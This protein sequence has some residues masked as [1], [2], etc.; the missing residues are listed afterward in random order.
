[1]CFISGSL[2]ELMVY[3]ICGMSAPTVLCLGFNML[4]KKLY[5]GNAWGVTTYSG[6]EQI[7]ESLLEK[8]SFLNPILFFKNDLASHSQFMRPLSTDVPEDV[9]WIVIAG[10]F[11]ALIIMTA[12]AWWLLRCWK[13]E[14]SGITG[15]NR[16]MAEMTAAFTGFIVFSF[17]FSY[18]F[19]S[20]I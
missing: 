12:A 11:A 2:M 16:L 15:N 4:M 8:F 10:W 13:A 9:S 5:W 3:W 19:I 14:N 17:V 7:R 1:M 6:A 20:M 18:L